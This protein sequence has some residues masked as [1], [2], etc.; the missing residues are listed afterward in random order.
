MNRFM[1]KICLQ[2]G[3]AFVAITLCAFTSVE[4]A[5]DCALIPD[6]SVLAGPH[7]SQQLLV[8]SVAS[9]RFTGDRTAKAKFAS[10]NPKVATVDDKGIVHPVTDGEVTI[11]ADVNGQMAAA[12]VSVTDGGR[13]DGRSFRNEVQPVLAE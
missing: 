12:V 9:G 13:Q 1:V 8:E 5:S 10:S 4:A 11:T 7:A 6:K 2:R 3:L